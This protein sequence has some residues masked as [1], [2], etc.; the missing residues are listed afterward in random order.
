MPRVLCLRY[1]ALR[2]ERLEALDVGLRERPFVIHEGAARSQIKSLRVIAVSALARAA[3]LRPGSSV[4][5]ARMACSEI[6]TFPEDRAADAAAL[7]AL[8][9]EARRW[10]PRVGLY[11]DDAVV[12]ILD[13]DSRLFGGEA[14]VLRRARANSPGFEC[15]AAIASSPARALARVHVSPDTIAAPSVAAESEEM[16]SW[17]VA[18]LGLDLD[19]ELELESLGVQSLGA[20]VELGPRDIAARWPA[21]N[22]ILAALDEMDLDP[23]WQPLSD[24]E[25]DCEAIS[26][27][28]PIKQRDA[29]QAA[30]DLILERLMLRLS[31]RLGP[32][33]VR[34][35]ELTLE[36][37]RARETLNLSA[38]RPLCSAAA[39][40]ALILE[41]F[42][43]RVLAAP[44]SGLQ[45]RLTRLEEPRSR[46][47]EAFSKQAGREAPI[48]GLVARL[49]RWLG[50]GRVG[51]PVLADDH[52]PEQRCHL[53][54]FGQETLGDSGDLWRPLRLY[55]PPCLR[56]V[57]AQP[58]GGGAEGWLEPIAIQ[59][60]GEW[61]E[62]LRVIGP[63]R[64]SC[65]WEPRLD[66]DYFAV[67]SDPG[68]W[69][70]VYHDRRGG[71]WY[72][73]GV[74]D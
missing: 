12:V 20:L 56:A 54:P 41:H 72:E 9:Q 30:L 64:L 39:I 45:L 16:A 21:L 28:P 13:R 15:Q 19:L 67:E 25:D 33:G 60:Q 35:L 63:E 29:L 24:E 66:R 10:G 22:R 69:L 48:Q 43:H 46:V 36:S 17:P 68:R 51:R 57:R 42:D 31:R 14:S 74:F 26:L 18:A 62:L 27:D 70:W 73:H 38:G 71:E 3:G 59:E 5:E 7:R 37:A 44:L 58:V 55:E 11:G 65:A 40:S 32:R 1:P 47:I 50:P 23:R 2:S 6:E 53:G 49:E 52:R 34:A 4:G 8:A 61:R